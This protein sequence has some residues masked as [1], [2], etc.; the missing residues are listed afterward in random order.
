MKQGDD[1]PRPIFSKQWSFF[2]G[3]VEPGETPEEAL[4]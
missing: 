1:L 2:G 3:G 4:R